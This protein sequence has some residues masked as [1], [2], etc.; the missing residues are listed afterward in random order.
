MAEIVDAGLLDAI[1]AERVLTQVWN[2]LQ[3]RHTVQLVPWNDDPIAIAK[4]E[5]QQLAYRDIEELIQRASATMKAQVEQ[6]EH[7]L[8]TPDDPSAV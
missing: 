7:E 1:I 8:A 5:G 3:E 4:F 6:I 2:F